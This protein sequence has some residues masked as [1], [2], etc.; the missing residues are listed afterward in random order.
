VTTSPGRRPLSVT[1]PACLVFIVSILNL[2][3]LILTLQN[4]EFL[5]VLIPM[6]PAY[7]ALSGLFWS[8]LG[9]LLTWGIWLGKPWAPKLTLI[10]IVAYSIYYWS[11][12][13]F[14]PGYPQ[15]VSGSNFL[16]GLNLL[17]AMWSL[18]MLSRPKARKFFGE[19]NEKKS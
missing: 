12:R 11:D 14:A 8:L 10:S 4:W 2:T 7:L 5:D 18:W 1:L 6:S 19:I 15:R 16:I 17:I 9:L 13:L 3:R